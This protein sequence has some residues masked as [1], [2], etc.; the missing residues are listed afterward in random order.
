MI[1]K[2]IARCFNLGLW[3]TNNT[4]LGFL[5]YTTLQ[6]VGFIFG[7]ASLLG[8]EKGRIISTYPICKLNSIGS[9][10]TQWTGLNRW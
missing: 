9:S 4:T 1:I 10:C 6:E 8:W 2:Y 5:Y 3:C 7:V